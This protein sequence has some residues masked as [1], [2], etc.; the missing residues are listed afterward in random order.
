MSQRVVV[1]GASSAIGAAIVERFHNAGDRV[2]G[3]SLEESSDVNLDL[4]IVADCS[5]PD[6]VDA[7]IDTAAQLLG[8]IDVLV[9]AAG[10][11][12]V[13]PAHHTSNDQWR[14]ALSAC[15]DSY[16]FS[17]RA[18]IRHMRPGAAIVAISSLNSHLAAPWLAAYSAAKGGVDALTRQL[19]V[20]YGDR[21][22]RTNAVAPGLVGG[23]GI[24]DAAA[25]YPLGRT[26]TAIEVAEAVYFLGS[27]A[28]SGVNGVVLPVDG[29][30]S[31][32]SPSASLRADLR[33]RL[34]TLPPN[35]SR[36]PDA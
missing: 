3:V 17:A 34:D 31:V 20:E 29:G 21:G 27:S 13:A 15:L 16:F 10:V 32:A 14:L 26:I 33:A 22:I 24:P 5:Q 7:A 30:V 19:S 25:G 8:G 36:A 18:A 12:P 6:R 1:I 9:A 35:E 28:A 23:D 4:A 2:V 11:M